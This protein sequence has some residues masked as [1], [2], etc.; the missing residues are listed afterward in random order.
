[1]SAAVLAAVGE[2]ASRA[3][4]DSTPDTDTFS[5]GDMPETSISMACRA[6]SDSTITDGLLDR[7]LFEAHDLIAIGGGCMIMTEDV[8]ESPP[9]ASALV[10]LAIELALRGDPDTLD[11]SM[12]ICKFEQ[13]RDRFIFKAN[14]AGLDSAFLKSPLAPA[15]DAIG[16]ALNSSPDGDTRAV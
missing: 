11:S 7:F 6:I 14:S 2:A 9:G 1:M 12:V 8:G 15:A 16:V 3:G 13:E 10:P 5:A 4:M